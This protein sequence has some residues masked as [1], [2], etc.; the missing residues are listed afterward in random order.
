MPQ[1]ELPRH[2][3]DLAAAERLYG[4]PEAPW[5]DLSTG[6]NPRPYPLPPLPDRLW[7]RLP[8]AGE[9]AALLAAAARFFGVDA[10]AGVVAAP[11]TQALIQLLPRLRPPGRVAILA[12]TYDEH[13]L[14]WTAAGHQV[15]EI[16]HLDEFADADVVVVVNP[17][18]PDGRRLSPST[19]TALTRT[20]A[21]RDGLVVVDEAFADAESQDS[22]AGSC[23]QP[24]LVVL[25]SFGKFFGL[26]GL[27]LGFAM[28][29]PPLAASIVEALGP[30]SVSAP[31]IAVGTVALTDDAWGHATR[32]WLGEMARR[33]DSVLGQAGLDVIGGTVLFRLVR[34]PHAQPLYHALGRRGILV[35][36]FTARTD[37]L[38]FG[39]PDSG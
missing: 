28:A 5:L 34:T 16:A 35:R 24:G 32:L 36:A 3:G 10:G 6:I 15:R 19:L 38:R 17:N 12:P 26:A 20:L 8:E 23:G 2:G 9:V 7:H 31:A 30:W 18:N 21:A 27:R 25:R 1:N 39:L 37:R 13:A 22:L 4:R 33:L 11:G 14:A 29:A